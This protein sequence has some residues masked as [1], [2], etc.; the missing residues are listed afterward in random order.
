MIF[1]DTGAWIALSDRKDQYHH[2]AV[3]IYTKLK[4]EKERLLT[5]DYIIN[6]TVTR[7]RYDLNHSVAVRFLDSMERVEK[8]DVLRMICIDEPLFDDAI[9]IFRTYDTAV[10]SFT[11]CISFAVCRKYKIDLAFAFDQHFIMMGIA[12]CVK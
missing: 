6:E 12:L 4:Q 5:T 8:A 11:D 7:L 3:A 1:I 9:S 2:N 10:L